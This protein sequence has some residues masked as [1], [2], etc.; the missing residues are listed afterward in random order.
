MEL[1]FI[2]SLFVLLHL[3]ECVFGC[4]GCDVEPIV[5][6]VDDCMEFVRRYPE[7][8]KGFSE[9]DATQKD[10]KVAIESITEAIWKDSLWS[11]SGPVKVLIHRIG[12]L[13]SHFTKAELEA[14][15]TSDLT[16]CYEIRKVK[17][18]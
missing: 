18:S 13:S 4:I 6:Q 3:K 2:F 5:R 8:A 16:Q 11:A 9:K 15:V 12:D 17:Y 10:L 14:E 7:E 1:K